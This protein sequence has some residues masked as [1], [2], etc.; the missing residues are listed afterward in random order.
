[1]KSLKLLAAMVLAAS[2]ALI[3][4]P[5]AYAH[6]EVV[7]TA[8]AD[9]AT[10]AAGQIDVS[11]TFSEDILTVSNDGAIAIRVTAP[12]NTV[13]THDCL[14][15]NGA[16]ISTT[17]DVDQPGKYQVDWQSVSADGHPATG[18]F[19]FTVTND[20][21]YVAQPEKACGPVLIAP[22]PTESATPMLHDALPLADDKQNNDATGWI[23]TGVGVVLVALVYGGYLWR[24]RKLAAAKPAD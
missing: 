13:L 2:S 3:M 22:G 10:V 21:G 18:A 8:P 19:S 12:D 5:A 14:G 4:A 24:R 11:V 9:G 20:N 16:V 6:D 15:V 7:A 1:M 17:V 23:W